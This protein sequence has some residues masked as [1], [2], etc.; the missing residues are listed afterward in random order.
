MRFTVLG[1]GSG[2]NATLVAAGST[3]LLIDAGFSGRELTRRM[4]AMGVAP[5]EI[6][7]VVLTHEHTDHVRGAG[8]F[9]RAHGTPLALTDGTL[10]ACGKLFRGQETLRTYRPGRPFEVGDLVVEP[11]ATVHDAAD[12]V[13]MAVVEGASGL[14][15]GVATD[16]GRPTALARHVLA[17]CDAL[18]VESN[19]DEALVWSA[20]YPPQVKARIAS[21]H[22]HL[23]NRAAAEL[24]CELLGPRLAVVVLAHLSA[25]SNRP[26]LAERTMRSAL[27]R[28]GYLGDVLVASPTDPTEMIDLAKLRSASRGEQLPLL[29][30]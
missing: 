4:K 28:R 1:S 12:P 30:R 27:A 26:G 29:E 7:L 15:L 3:H 5:E 8:V 6:D 11:F 19:H 14:R 21:S 17:E 18:I 24:V 22:G 13:A 10:A 9:A 2:G 25:E 23:S 16:L 20:P